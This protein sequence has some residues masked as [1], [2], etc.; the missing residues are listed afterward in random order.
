MS[1]MRRVGPYRARDGWLMGV[2]RGFSRYADIPVVWVRVVMVAFFF[3]AG[4]WPALLI[5][6]LAAILM[7]PAPALATSTDEDAEFYQSYASNRRMALE[8]LKRQFDQMDRRTRRLE[9]IVT[10]RGYDW[11]RRMGDVGESR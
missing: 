6:F 11:D 9:H 8:R 2:C 1:A 4:F 10:A 7:P 3:V 5:Y